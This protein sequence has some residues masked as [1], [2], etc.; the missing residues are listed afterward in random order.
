MESEWIDCVCYADSFNVF[1]RHVFIGISHN[2]LTLSNVPI[3]IEPIIM[4]TKEFIQKANKVHNKKYTYNQSV[5][6]KG[7]IKLK[8]ECPIHGI[9]EQAPQDHLSGRGCKECKKITLSKL[10]RMDQKTFLEKC[11]KIHD[12]KY[13]YSKS[14]YQDSHSKIVI[15][16]KIHG[17]FNQTPTSHLRGR[18]CPEC[19]KLKTYSLTQEEF[20]TRA[21]NIHGGKYNYVQSIYETMHIKL[22]IECP[23]HGIFKQTPLNHLHGKNG[24]PKCKESKGEIEIRKFLEFNNLTFIGQWKSTSCKLKNPLPFDFMVQIDNCI[25]LIE[26][27]GQQHYRI[28]S[29][30]WKGSPEQ[31]AAIKLRDEIKQNWC[32]AN[33]IPLLTIK[34]NEFDLIESKIKNFLPL[35]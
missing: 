22:I 15:I 9:F 18:G 30:I 6:Q 3:S 24:C 25:Y 11:K 12:N 33:K 27:H 31:L 34:Y 29:G 10:K 32:S 14:E 13:D 17:K 2:P 19:G 28:A 8:I 35:F 21:T 4:D 7:R 26:F 20:I 5:Y 23:K 16:C 1:R